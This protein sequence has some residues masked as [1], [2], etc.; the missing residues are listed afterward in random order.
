MLSRRGINHETETMNLP[1]VIIIVRAPKPP[2]WLPQAVCSQE[3]FYIN[4]QLGS[5]YV[6][7]CRGIAFSNYIVRSKPTMRR[8]GQ[9]GSTS[10]AIHE[11]CVCLAVQKESHRNICTHYVGRGRILG[12]RVYLHS[13]FNCAPCTTAHRNR[14]VIVFYRE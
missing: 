14:T 8:R 11:K 6:S 13:R 1:C 3:F 12:T 2:R 9:Y 7:L 4:R 10:R 5:Q